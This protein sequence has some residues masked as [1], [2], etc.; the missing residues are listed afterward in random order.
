[1]TI[2][3]MLGQSGILAVLG[4]GI[5]FLFLFVMIICINIMGGIV[6]AFGRN[7]GETALPAT[8]TGQTTNKAVIAAITAAVN[9]Y[10]KD[11]S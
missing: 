8:G 6:K 1:M 2:F 10:H 5:V 7:K 3:D 11:N 4:T 9:K